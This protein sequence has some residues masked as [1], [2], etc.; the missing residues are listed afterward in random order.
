VKVWWA[1]LAAAVPLVSGAGGRRQS[2]DSAVAV[3]AVRFYRPASAVT[4]VE[5]VVGVRL[6]AFADAARPDVRY[7]LEVSVRDSTGLEL[8]HG[9]IDR[10]VPRELAQA[11]GAVAV[12]NFG[13]DVAPGSY[14]IHVRAVPESGS[15]VET[16]ASVAAFAVLPAISDLLVATGV[17]ALP[18]TAEADPAEV[19]RAG[20]AM[21]TAPVPLLRPTESGIAYYAELYPWQGAAPTGE[22]TVAVIDSAGRVV[23]RSA[24][25][26]VSI[27]P[28]GGVTRGSMD[29]AGLPAGEYRLGIRVRLGDSAVVSEAPFAMAGLPG[30]ATAAREVAGDAFDGASEERLDSLYAPLVYLMERTERVEYTAL[31]ADGKRRYLREFWQRRDPTPAV[32]GNPV[33]TEYYRA[34]NFANEAF[35][36]GGGAQIS[37]WRTDRGRIYLRNGRPDEVLRRPVASQ[38]PYEAWKYTRGR[39]RFYVFFDRTGFGHYELLGTNDQREM[40]FPDWQGYLGP[41][42]LQDVADFLRQFNIG[43][44]RD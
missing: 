40:S 12:A 5:G 4:R 30:P 37:G 15:P 25:R 32:A 33:M 41:D 11:P 21:R 17:R 27:A 6:A 9:Q 20:T 24:P 31:T 18:D 3:R 38:K 34:V 8:Q 36:E 28:E 1:A 10:V 16:S 13:F 2:G 35:R 22:L 39:P 29:L 19:R 42:G 44:S 14:R 7:R 43:I 23:V 26:Q